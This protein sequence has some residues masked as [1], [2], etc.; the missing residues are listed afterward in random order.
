MTLTLLLKYL[1]L[2]PHFHFSIKQ[3]S[4]TRVTCFAVSGGR[5]RTEHCCGAR[6][7]W[8]FQTSACKHHDSLVEEVRGARMPEA[9]PPSPSTGG[10]RHTSRVPRPPTPP[11]RRTQP[12]TRPQTHVGDASCQTP[13]SASDTECGSR[14]SSTPS[15]SRGSSR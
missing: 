12:L 6:I 11:K 8:F 13:S 3:K 10:H 2:P 14:E 9:P 7:L 5:L 15:I 1:K 4:Q